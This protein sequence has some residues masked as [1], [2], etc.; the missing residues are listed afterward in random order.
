MLY[1]VSFHLFQL[2]FVGYII[3]PRYGN[4]NLSHYGDLKELKR[5]GT[6]SKLYFTLNKSLGISL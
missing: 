6:H 4:F 2:Y 5:D 1:I 3:S